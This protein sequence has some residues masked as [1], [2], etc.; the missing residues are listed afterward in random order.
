[1]VSGLCLEFSCPEI[2]ILT[3]QILA[4]VR[5]RVVM[6]FGMVGLVRVAGVVGPWGVQNAL[7]FSCIAKALFHNYKVAMV[8]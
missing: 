5:V 1:M 2:T 4:N 7:V 8:T 6:V 3:S